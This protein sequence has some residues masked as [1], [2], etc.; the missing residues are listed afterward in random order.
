MVARGTEREGSFTSPVGISAVS[1]PEY[2]KITSTI[3]VPERLP[4]GQVGPVRRGAAAL[5][6]QHAGDREQ[7]EREQLRRREQRDGARAPA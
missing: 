3:E 2:A 4:G 6:Q 1:M 7:H 5:E